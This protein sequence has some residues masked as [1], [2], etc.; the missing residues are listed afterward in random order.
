[1]RQRERQFDRF[2]ALFEGLAAWL[3]R[4]DPSLP[5]LNP[6]APRMLVVGITELV[7]IEVR[8]G[9]LDRLDRLHDEVADLTRR[10]LA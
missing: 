1:V 4:A 8:M 9:R 2:V 3:R 5:P 7:A 10:L 6:L